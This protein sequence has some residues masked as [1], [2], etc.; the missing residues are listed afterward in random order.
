MGEPE[1][2]ISEGVLATVFALEP[3]MIIDISISSDN[4]ELSATT[5]L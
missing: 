4:P 1:T 5:H 2:L 3:L